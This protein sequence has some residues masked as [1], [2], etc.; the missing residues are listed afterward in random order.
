MNKKTLVLIAFVFLTVTTFAQT[1][2]SLV[3]SGEGP[4]KTEATSAAL[5]SA[6]EQAFGTF[7]S[8][9]TTILNDELVENEI[10]TVS[11]GNIESYEE[12]SSFESNGKWEVTLKASVSIDKLVN[13]VKGKGAETEFAGQTFALQMKMRALNKENE[14]QA[15]LNLVEQARL[16]TSNNSLFDYDIVQS[17]PEY[18]D[19]D[20]YRIYIDVR[21][22]KNKNYFIIRNLITKTFKS[23]ALT[24]TERTAY[25]DN[26]Y[27]RNYC[28]PLR[29]EGR[30]SDPE[31]Y[32]MR[33]EKEF[34]YAI[35]LELRNNIKLNAHCFQVERMGGGDSYKT[36]YK[37]Y[38]D[39]QEEY[40][41]SLE[42]PQDVLYNTSGFKVV[43]NLSLKEVEYVDLGLSVKWASCN[44]GAS[45]PTEYGG[46]YQWA[47]TKDV[48]DTR[49]ELYWSNC[50]YQT[51]SYSYVY[52]NSMVNLT[53]Y[54]TD[55]SHGTVDNKTVLELMDDAASV[56]RGEEWRI[57]TDEEW[58]ELFNN[59]SWTWTTID[60]VK[61][62]KV[63]SKKPGYTD[64]WIFLPAAGYRRF[65]D[66]DSVGSYG[67][68]WSSSL[69]SDKPTEA[70]GVYISSRSFGRESSDRFYGNSVRPVTEYWLGRL[71]RPL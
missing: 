25:S 35:E 31:S 52:V 14:K 48:S 47:G 43:P 39:I 40:S 13:Y 54:K 38:F 30:Y 28:S 67:K 20:K 29:F 61:G 64:N 12:I 58:T 3:V 32:C 51:N 5:R 4:T 6:I 66:L 45:K 46:Y 33:S 37:Q 56:A 7:V 8:A 2:V 22:T 71:C 1:T 21:A 16:L 53:K 15:L 69:N 49:I 65:N 10:A 55:S 9:N 18:V 11:S 23:L 62:Y 34:L 57:P 17:E 19:G 68:Y 24:D 59:C 63:Q 50:P 70:Y 27:P 36:F 42:I 41:F 44:L 26:H 60:G